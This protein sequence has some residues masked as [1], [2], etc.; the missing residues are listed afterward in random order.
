MEE[1]IGHVPPTTFL[2]ETDYYSLLVA[3]IIVEDCASSDF[4]CFFLSV[5][6]SQ[7][8]SYLIS[9]LRKLGIPKIDEKLATS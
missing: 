4:F 7:S 8:I 5:P 6:R 3:S 2:R 9:V 1:L